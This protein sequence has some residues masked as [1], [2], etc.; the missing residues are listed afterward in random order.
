MCFSVSWFIFCISILCVQC[1]GAGSTPLALQA[2]VNALPASC[3]L[4]QRACALNFLQKY[5]NK[6]E[7]KTVIGKTGN[8][9]GAIS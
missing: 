5:V 4:R 8:K 3:H 9:N 1:R 2:L 6:S 7:E